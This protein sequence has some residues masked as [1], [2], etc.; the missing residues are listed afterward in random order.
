MPNSTQVLY[1]VFPTDTW[2]PDEPGIFPKIYPSTS[3]ILPA[4]SPASDSE[5]L[6]GINKA[7]RYREVLIEV[8]LFIRYVEEKWN[9]YVDGKSSIESIAKFPIS[10]SIIE[11]IEAIEFLEKDSIF[12]RLETFP[13]VNEFLN[14]VTKYMNWFELDNLSSQK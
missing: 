7:A 12:S 13:T 11:G 9:A 6:N 2:F 10:F 5:W 8:L 1:G 3:P 4:Q 14:A